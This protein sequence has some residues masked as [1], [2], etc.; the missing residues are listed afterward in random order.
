MIGACVV[1]RGPG[2][3]L[4]SAGLMRGPWKMAVGR[5]GSRSAKG[6]DAMAHNADGLSGLVRSPAGRAL[7]SCFC[8]ASLV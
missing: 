7:E 3:G 6:P 4:K 2:A 5:G 1:L 8:R